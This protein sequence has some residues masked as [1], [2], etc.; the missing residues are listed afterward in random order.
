MAPE[1]LDEKRYPIM[2]DVSKID[3]WAL[4][5]LLIGMLTLDVGVPLADD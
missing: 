5:V 3:V 2:D 1:Q 4:G